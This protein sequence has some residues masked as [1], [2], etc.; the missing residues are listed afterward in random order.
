MCSGKNAD[1]DKVAVELYFS[2]LRVKKSQGFSHYEAKQMAYDAVELRYNIS[3]KRL[4]NII[5]KNHD[6]FNCNRNVFF[7]NNKRLIDTLIEA[8]EDLRAI[9]ERNIDLI[10]VLKEVEN[11]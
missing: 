6:T 1:R 8:N 3:K 11:V 2:V 10:N 5:S 7:D 4:Q 9:I